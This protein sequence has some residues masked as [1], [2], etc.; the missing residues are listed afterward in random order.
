MKD[1]V[2]AQKIHELEGKLHQLASDVK[3]LNIKYADYKVAV[4]SP[5]DLITKLSNLCTV[6]DAEFQ[7]QLSS[8]LEEVTNH[9]NGY[10]NIAK[11]LASKINKSMIDNWGVNGKPLIASEREVRQANLA[12][13]NEIHP[14]LKEI[15]EA[16]EKLR[17]PAVG[18]APNWMKDGAAVV[19]QS[20]V[21]NITSSTNF[22]YSK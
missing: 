6:D 1:K 22:N 10:F 9:Y 5:D 11:D 21:A 17:S 4:N 19:G 20:L 18:K 3:N 15:E 8:V 16:L 14:V 7:T 2:I 12:V 13:Y